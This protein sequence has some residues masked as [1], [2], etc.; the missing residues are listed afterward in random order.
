VFC[1]C[2]NLSGRSRVESDDSGGFG[3]V[4]NDILEYNNIEKSCAGECITIVLVFCV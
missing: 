1:G 3:V 2:G 4:S